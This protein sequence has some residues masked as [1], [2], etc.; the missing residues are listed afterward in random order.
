LNEHQV[1]NS[2]LVAAVVLAPSA[3]LMALALSRPPV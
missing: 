1:R 2:L 3:A